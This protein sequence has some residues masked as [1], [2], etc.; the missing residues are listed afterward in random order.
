MLRTLK[1]S[2]REAVTGGQRILH[3]KELY[4]SPCVIRIL[5]SRR[6]RWVGHVACIKGMRRAYTVVVVR[7]EAKRPLV[8][9]LF[10]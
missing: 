7:T 9:Q 10:A 6:K 8:K 2:N 3:I 5:K 1:L 4:C